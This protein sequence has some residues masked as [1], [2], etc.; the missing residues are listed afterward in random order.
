MVENGRKEFLV[1]KRR[2]GISQVLKKN[3]A[4]R[5]RFLT[6]VVPLFALSM[7]ALL[8]LVAILVKLCA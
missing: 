2:N 4:E 1:R 8:G 5:R 7:A 3:K 6:I